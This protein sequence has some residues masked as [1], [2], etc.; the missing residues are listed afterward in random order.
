VD[1]PKV[2]GARNVQPVIVGFPSPLRAKSTTP[3]CMLGSFGD[4]R[5]SCRLYNIPSS[6]LYNIPSSSMSYGVLKVFS[7]TF[8]G[9]QYFSRYLFTRTCIEH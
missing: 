6:R 2:Q 5:S 8:T 3:A 4:S 7:K 1:N 9:I